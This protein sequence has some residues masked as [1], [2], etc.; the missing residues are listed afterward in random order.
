MYRLIPHRKEVMKNFIIALSLVLF[1]IGSFALVGVI[2]HYA[3]MLSI[4]IFGSALSWAILEML[5]EL[6]VID[7]DLSK[8]RQEASLRR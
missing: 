7:Y 8:L 5:R 1:I 6:G 2:T 4:A 3:P